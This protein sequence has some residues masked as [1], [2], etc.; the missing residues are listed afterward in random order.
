ML[1][2]LGTTSCHLEVLEACIMRLTYIFTMKIVSDGWLGSG[3]DL[4][5]LI[6][7]EVNL[8][9][10]HY[11]IIHYQTTTQMKLDMSL[12]INIKFYTSR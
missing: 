2:H 7:I 4:T 9:S 10:I 11:T 1:F 5:I 8:Y 3:P 12:G 6:H